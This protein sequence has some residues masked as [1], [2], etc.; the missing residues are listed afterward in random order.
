MAVR[1]VHCHLPQSSSGPASLAPSRS[2]ITACW[3]TASGESVE[4]GIS[5]SGDDPYAAGRQPVVSRLYVGRQAELAQLRAAATQV[6][7]GGS[8]RILIAGEA[9]IGK[10]RLIT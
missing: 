7:T 5:M 1:S 10:S 8:A 2:T 6:E 9:G 3:Q 4:R